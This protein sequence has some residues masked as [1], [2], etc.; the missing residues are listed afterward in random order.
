[1]TKTLRDKVVA[2]YIFNNNNQG[3]R[4][5]SR[6]SNHTLGCGSGH[7]LTVLEFEL[8]IRLC[9][10]TVEAAWNPLSPSLSLPLPCSCCVCLT[11]NLKKNNDDDDDN[12]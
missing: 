4:G 5:L 3:A 1:M 9:A 7:D 2:R 11:I 10:D 12:K 6:L 8:H